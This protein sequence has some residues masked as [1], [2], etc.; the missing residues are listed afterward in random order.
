MH[1][2]LLRN[3]AVVAKKGVTLI[4]TIM[5]IV[6]VSIAVLGVTVFIVQRFAELNTKV[7]SNKCLYLAQAGV[8][9]AIEQVRSR[10]SPATTYGYYPL[11][12]TTVNT[13]ETF[14]RGGTAAD[15]LIVNSADAAASSSDII[16]IKIQEATNSATPAVILDQMVVTW[17]QTATRRLTA[18]NIGG[19]DKWTGNL[20]S[21]ATCNITNV[22]L[23]TG[24]TP[25]TRLRFNNSASVITSISIQFIM[26]DGSS[27]TVAVY[28]KN[29]NS[30]FTIKSTGKVSGSNIYRTQ[31]VDYNL[32]NTTTSA[33]IDDYDEINTEII[34]P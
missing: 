12:L 7:I 23:G 21:P 34:S 16:N 3:G 10:F 17:T 8:Q 4:E 27:K 14:R 25:I 26:T 15:M 13:G 20:T 9:D 6:F 28:P 2:A 11:G 18:I 29:N 19:S 5:L 30:V 32:M 24:I 1:W 31:E 33:R 22:T